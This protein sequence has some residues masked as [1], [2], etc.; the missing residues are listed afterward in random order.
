MRATLRS[1]ALFALFAASAGELAAQRGGLRPVD[2][3]GPGGRGVWL[4]VGVAHGEEHYK[5]DTD[6]YWHGGFTAPSVTLAGGGM[7]SPKFGLGAEWNIWNDYEAESDQRLQALSIVGHWYPFGPWL[8]FKGGLGLGFN[9]I[10]DATGLFTDTGVGTTL[11]LGVDIPVARRLSL[12]PRVDAYYQRYNDA[13]Q[14]NDYKE[15]L[16]QVGVALRY[17]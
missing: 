11:G 2:E 12:E 10:D 5:F 17:H 16:V 6:G 14:A 15:R 8:Y 13:G 4:L 7:V 1:L 3:S 9:R